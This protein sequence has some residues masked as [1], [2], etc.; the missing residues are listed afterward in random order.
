MIVLG[1]EINFNQI[2]RKI[3]EYGCQI[4]R[5]AMRQMLTALDDHLAVERQTEIRSNCGLFS[6]VFSSIAAL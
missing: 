2:E 3:F 4:A 6:A 5:E 1:N